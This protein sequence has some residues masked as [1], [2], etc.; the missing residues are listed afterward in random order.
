[1]SPY[2]V[3]VSGAAGS[4][5]LPAVPLL[6]SRHINMWHAT[7]QAESAIFLGFQRQ[8]DGTMHHP[9]DDHGEPSDHGKRDPNGWQATPT[10]GGWDSGVKAGKHALAVR[11]PSW[12]E[13][14]CLVQSL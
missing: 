11:G 9:A 12:L 10:T 1:M 14:V 2:D 3:A 5:Q 6:I 8:Q 7:L 4:Y 13:G